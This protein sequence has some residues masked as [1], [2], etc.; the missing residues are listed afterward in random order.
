VQLGRKRSYLR[1]VVPILELIYRNGFVAGDGKAICG[2]AGGCAPKQSGHVTLRQQ[3]ER[4]R[5]QRVF[6]A[7]QQIAIRF[8]VLDV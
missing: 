5:C 6:V 7:E 1:P 2:E 3:G 4:R 8:G